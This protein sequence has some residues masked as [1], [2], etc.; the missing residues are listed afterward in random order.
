MWHQPANR[1]RPPRESASR[2]LVGRAAAAFTTKASLGQRSRR[3]APR[4]AALGRTTTRPDSV[5]RRCVEVRLVCIGRK[6]GAG[7][8]QR[9][10]SLICRFPLAGGFS[11]DE[12]VRGALLSAL[13]WMQPCQV[14]Q[15]HGQRRPRQ[16]V[17][18]RQ[19]VSLCVGWWYTWRWRRGGVSEAG[20][21]THQQGE[22]GLITYKGEHA[23]VLT[24]RPA[25]F[26]GDPTGERVTQIA[27]DNACGLSR[28]IASRDPK[29]A[30]NL[31]I[32]HDR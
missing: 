28:Y 27:Y 14:L 30:S 15:P 20:I 21:A 9:P 29:A 1:C 16:H 13:H 4:P 8:A 7:V 32:T 25:P 17:G 2:T 18:P 22:A 6:Q 5:T 19:A 24:P 23:Q 10:P 12:A 26:A 3:T 31:I 11:A